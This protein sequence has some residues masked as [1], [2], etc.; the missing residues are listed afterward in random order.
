MP[1]PPKLKAAVVGDPVAHSL[2]PSLFRHWAKA[3]GLAVE[4]EALKVT[5]AAFRETLSY[6]RAEGVWAGWSVTLPHKELAAQLCDEL[7][8]SAELAGAV[9]AVQFHDGLA[10]GHNTDGQGFLDALAAAGCVPFGARAVVLGAGG[11][12]AGVVAALRRAGAAEVLV[13]NRTPERAGRLARRFGLAYGGL[14]A[15]PKLVPTADL[16]VNATAA[17]LEGASPLPEGTR[18]REGAWAMDLLYRPK[19]TPFLAQARAAGARPVA[20][21]GMLVGQAALAW[22]LFFGDRLTAE[23]VRAGEAY[24]EGLL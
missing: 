16:V 14:D 13:L 24:L 10:V 23:Q 8:A 5:H 17:G 9:N 20:G 15:A 22:R 6:A 19:Q 11:A 7:D 18:F 21:L 1:E 4:Y 3:R 12:A 2:S